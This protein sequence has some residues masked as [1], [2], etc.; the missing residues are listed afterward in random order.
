MSC[1]VV[2]SRNPTH[3]LRPSFAALLRTFSQPSFV[4]FHWFDEDKQAGGPQCDV[5][6]APLEASA[7]L[8][9]DLQHTYK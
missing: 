7:N 4:V 6:G 9:L 8:Y 1:F 5:L 2:Y 3:R